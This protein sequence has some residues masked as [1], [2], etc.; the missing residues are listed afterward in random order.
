MRTARLRRPYVFQYPLDVSTDREPEMN[1]F[2]Q[3][4]SLHQQMSL[5]GGEEMVVGG[6][7]SVQRLVGLY[8]EV[9]CIMVMVTW[10]QSP[11]NRMTDTTE[12]ITFPQLRWRVVNT[13]EV[14]S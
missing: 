2:E 8:N 3:V 6:G 10:D 9:Q 13:T 14:F 7:G 4:S 12:N 11:L 1:K 5:A